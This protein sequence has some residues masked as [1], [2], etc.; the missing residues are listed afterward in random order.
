L[1]LYFTARPVALERAL[2]IVLLIHLIPMVAQV[3][4]YYTT[5]T[6]LDL[7]APLTGELQRY[8]GYLAAGVIRPT[9]LHSE[10]TSY[11]F[12]MVVLVYL[13]RR[14]SQPL[15]RLDYLAL[16]SAVINYSILGL[17]VASLFMSMRLVSSKNVTT[18]LF[19]TAAGLLLGSIALAA[20][21]GSGGSTYSFLLIQCGIVLSLLLLGL[22]VWQ[23]H[24]V[25]R[26]R[27]LTILFLFVLFIGTYQPANIMF[28]FMLA[29]IAVLDR[30]ADIKHDNRDREAWITREDGLTTPSGIVPVSALFRQQRQ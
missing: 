28:W 24:S 16:L 27:G 25:S 20:Q 7:L 26:V 29:S 19:W 6:Y 22:I 21:L 4:V 17:V 8:N 13:R 11:S 14:F 1:C 30:A 10:P 3:L 23:L 15:S 12:C 18:N 5:G 9:G 2:R